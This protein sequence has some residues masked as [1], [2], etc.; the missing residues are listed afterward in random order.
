MPVNGGWFY[1]IIEC[2]KNDTVTKRMG[3]MVLIRSDPY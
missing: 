2:D 3:N 1:A